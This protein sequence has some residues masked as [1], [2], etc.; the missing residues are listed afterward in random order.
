MCPKPIKTRANADECASYPIPVD[1][2][3]NLLA[4][5]LVNALVSAFVD[6]LVHI[7]GNTL[8]LRILL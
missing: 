3:V 2:L 6:A 1:T 5:A 4:N 7:L 8:K